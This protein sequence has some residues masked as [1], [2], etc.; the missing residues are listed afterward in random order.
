MERRVLMVENKISSIISQIRPRNVPITVIFGD[1]DNFSQINNK[2]GV[3]VGNSVIQI[4][5]EF[6][7]RTPA[8]RYSERIGGDEFVACLVGL[9]ET[10]VQ[11]AARKLVEKIQMYPWI[12]IAPELYVTISVGITKRERDD[13]VQRLLL[14]AI[15]GSVLAKRLGGNRVE[16]EINIP[17]L[18]KDP[19]TERQEIM[20]S[21]G[22]YERG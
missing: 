17:S 3:E 4:I 12:R 9:N 7:S 2:H 14:R 21:L 15:R 13:P 16:M 18:R 20:A 5:G 6:F 1:L 22:E 8:Q 11:I 19:E 10:Q